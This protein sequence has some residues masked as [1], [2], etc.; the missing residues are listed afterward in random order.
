MDFYHLLNRGVDKRKVFLDDADYVRFLHD[1]YVF[2]DSA[3][4]DPNHRLK[5]GSKGESDHTRKRLIT[6]HAFA[7][8]PNHYHMLV[9]EVAE[10]G[11]SLFMRKLN[12]GYSKYFNEK[13][14]RSG[15]LWQ[16][17]FR[18]IHIKRDAH[19]MYIPYYIHLNPLD[20]VL[21]SWRTSCI[22][23]TQKALNYLRKY[24]WSSFQDY[25]DIPNMPSL[26]NKKY[27]SPILGTAKNQEKEIK[28]IVSALD[29]VK[30]ANVL[31]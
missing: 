2:N 11:M 5:K 26:I 19:F 31:E 12:M 10:G 28:S 14:D 20:L 3:D 25:N 8:M 15:V 30:A 27:L 17:T 7:L 1:C 24:R 16:G 4:V 6:L 9:S 18:K 13:Y 29:L 22:Q 23:N 21:P